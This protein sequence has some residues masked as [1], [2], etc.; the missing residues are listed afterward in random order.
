MKRLLFISA[1]NAPFVEL[2]KEIIQKKYQVEE[3]IGGKLKKSAWNYLRIFLIYGWQM[4][5]NDIVYCWFADYRARTGVFWAGVFRKKAIVV[6]GGYEVRDIVY[7]DDAKALHFPYILRKA[8]LLITVS[9]HYQKCLQ[10]NFPEH[11]GKMK[12]IYNGMK[13]TDQGKAVI[14]KENLVVTVCSGS[15][16]SRFQEKGL[17]IFVGVASKFPTYQFAIIGAEG[18]LAEVILEKQNSSNLTII[19]LL[20]EAELIK[21]YQRAK[22]YCQF[23]RH[24]SFGL[25]L[26]EAMSWQCI[27]VVNGIASLQER[28]G[29]SGFILEEASMQQAEYCV[30]QAASANEETGIK[31]AERAIKLYD[32]RKR[33]DAILNILREI[34]D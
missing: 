10:K 20:K 21:W 6:I 28:V 29:E 9:D 30:G 4:F 14:K 27:P 16:V 34:A 13:I 11:A 23:S 22:V 3:G 1:Y 31:V 12:M 19:P 24:E 8:D 32:I 2:D 18:E 5:R 26:V 33:E 7:G 17:D 15:I 25:A